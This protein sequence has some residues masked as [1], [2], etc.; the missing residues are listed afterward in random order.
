M[1]V[2]WWQVYLVMPGRLSSWTGSVGP[3]QNS[4]FWRCP[5]LLVRKT[6]IWVWQLTQHWVIH[7][8]VIWINMSGLIYWSVTTWS[9]FTNASL[10]KST[11]FVTKLLDQTERQGGLLSHHW[12][13]RHSCKQ[14]SFLLDWSL[15]DNSSWLI[16][17][18]NLDHWSWQT[19]CLHWSSP[20]SF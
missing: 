3:A 10:A 8:Q 16:L 4:L 5:K 6:T 12:A 1:D 2:L 15:P 18:K 17:A 11:R 14:K 9:I 7:Y 19:N 20:K 13:L